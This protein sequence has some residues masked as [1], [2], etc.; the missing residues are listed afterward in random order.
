MTRSITWQFL[1]PIPAICGIALAIAAWLVPALIHSAA[2]ENAIAEARRTVAQFQQVRA[3]YAQNVVAKVT[4]ESTIKAG[5]DHKDN[6]ALIP[7]PTTMILDMS[8]LLHGQ[9]TQFRFYSPYPFPTRK[10][11]QV[12]DFG[13]AAWT[14]L[15]QN[16]DGLYSRTETMEG[17]PTVRVAVADRMVAQS[18][19]D[20]HN[21]H[22]DSP[23][24][25]WRLG[26]VRGVMELDMDIAGPL[27]RGGTLTGSILWGGAAAAGLLAAAAMLL[28]QRIS[29][30]IRT[31]TL[32]MR[33]LAG[34]DHA[35]EVP[36]IG[37]ADEIG[38]MAGAVQVFKENMA[39]AE[40]L[41]A[42][43]DAARTAKE[44]RTAKLETLLHG[45]QSSIGGLVNGLASASSHLE[46]T[47]QSMTAT[48]GQTDQQ[49][50]LVVT[51]AREASSNVETV[52]GA[53][54]K[55]TQSIGEVR[56]RIAQSVDSTN[57]A[58]LDAQRTE[59]IVRALAEGARKIGDVVGL[60]N[61]IAGQTNLLALNAMIEASRAGDAGRGFAVV[62]SEV[63]DLARQTAQATA[64]ISQQIA[65]IQTATREAVGAIEAITRIIE[66]A[67]ATA[68]GIADVIDQQGRAT[69]EIARSA[70]QTATHAQDVSTTIAGVSEAAVRTGT[71]AADVLSS[72]SDLAKQADGLSAAV[73]GFVAGIREA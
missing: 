40:S 10:D 48:A 35:V 71:E 67:S 61:A 19:V 6:P 2:V 29:R 69:D 64:E 50:A 41:A 56:S 11:R 38:T 70:R 9:G 32:A 1:L 49:A 8:D 62:A 17:K 20:C 26:D 46:A 33:R 21:S 47:A 63:K 57:R 16:P 39:R 7:L 51:A 58:A 68:A 18:C 30:P 55:L 73:R 13:T 44:Q 72:A 52:A 42:E 53:A 34:G 3:Y 5:A 28:A 37:R 54:G 45:F 27:A 15:A 36:A 59:A 65:E 14:Y 12:D 66:S 43:Q 31:M 24:R 23:K 25:D 60:I 4:E 22:P